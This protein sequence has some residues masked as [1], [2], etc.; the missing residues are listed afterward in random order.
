VVVLTFVIGVLNLALGFALA[1]RLGYGP[2]NLAAA[3]GTLTFKPARVNLQSN[4]K[5]SLPRGS[6]ASETAQDIADDA[7]SAA[8]ETSNAINSPEPSYWNLDEKYVETSVLKFNIAMLKSMARCGKIEG[9]LRSCLGRLDAETVQACLAELKDDCKI[10]LAQQ[11][12]AAEQL[13]ARLSEMGEMAALGE[14]I[15]VANLEQAAQIETTLNNLDYMDFQSDLETAGHR[16]LQEIGLLRA[17]RHNMYDN[18]EVAFLSIARH[19]NRL[20]KIEPQLCIDPLTGKL[21]RIGLETTLHKWWQ[22]GRHKTQ[23]I[24]GVIYDLDHFSNINEKHGSLVGDRIIS[25]V[26]RFMQQS[27]GKTDL[28]GRFRSDSFL[29]VWLDAGPQATRKHAET[30]RQS[31]D[32]IAFLHAD[33]SIHVT[34]GGGIAEILPKDSPDTYLQRLDAALHTAQSNGPNRLYFH[35]GEK[36]VLVEAPSFGAKPIE[37]V[38]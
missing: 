37:I 38:V 33:D 29:V 9:K 25:E 28:I 11:S 19:Q 35:D 21:N 15:T 17:S 4:D 31:I 2:P 5:N 24:C 18:Q 1:M 36:C 8:A 20:D 3:W 32:K 22:E 27:I 12:Q 6:A 7:T 13:N 26:V 23:A 16:L 34:V 10:Y 30:L 14:Q